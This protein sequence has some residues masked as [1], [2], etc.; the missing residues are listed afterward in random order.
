MLLCLGLFRTSLNLNWIHGRNSLKLAEI[1]SKYSDGT[2]SVCPDHN[3]PG[4]IF[5]YYVRRI[6]NEIAAD[7]KHF[8]MI[9]LPGRF[10]TIQYGIWR[11]LHIVTHQRN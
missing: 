4:S 2:I 9:I 11:L 5:P 3:R 1:F 7:P 8:S 10:F 6:L